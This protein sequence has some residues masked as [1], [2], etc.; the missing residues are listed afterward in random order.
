MEKAEQ[1]EK[2]VTTGTR[3]LFL[4]TL[5]NIGCQY[6]I[7]ED[8]DDNIFFVF[9][10]EHF[11][12]DTT[13]DGYYVHL[14]DTHWEHVELYDI[15]E[16]TRLRKAIN[17]ANIKCATTTVYT[18]DEAGGTVD[19]HCKASILFVPQIPDIGDYLCMELND[20]FR[21]H[22]FVEIEMTKLREKECANNTD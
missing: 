9:Q 16:F 3:D 6:E 2:T 1:N 8:D 21:A 20:F 15:D 10:G 13:N 19:V 18:I 5:T 17:A 22:R 12:A 14:L 4:Q 7:D 11:I